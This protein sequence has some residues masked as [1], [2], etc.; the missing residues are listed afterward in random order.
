VLVLSLWVLAVRAA[1]VGVSRGLV[2]LALVWGLILPILGLTQ[3][4]LAPGNAH[5]TIQILHLLVGLGAIGQ[6]EALAVG[7]GRTEKQV[8]AAV[9]DLE[10]PI[11]WGERT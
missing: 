5:W 4:R 10:T 2:V 1:Q 11:G 8:R 3:T 6:G 7:I 9:N